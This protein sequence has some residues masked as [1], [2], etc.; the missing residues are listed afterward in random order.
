MS[1][2]AKGVTDTVVSG[3]RVLLR[4]GVRDDSPLVVLNTFGDE[5]RRVLD[6]LLQMTD[7]DFSLAAVSDIDWD[8]EMSP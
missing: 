5:G 8:R 6:T 7:A 2:A 3:R 1:D 4:R